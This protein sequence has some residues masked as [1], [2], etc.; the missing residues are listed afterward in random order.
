MLLENILWGCSTGKRREET[1]TVEEV[2]SW[3]RRSSLL[4]PKWF[5][6]KEAL[7]ITLLNNCLADG[8]TER[9]KFFKIS[10]VT[11]LSKSKQM[12]VLWTL[13]IRE[14]SNHTLFCVLTH[15][16]YRWRQSYKS[17]D[18]EYYSALK[19]RKSCYLRQQGW[20]LRALCW[21]Q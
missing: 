4:R 12:T 15:Y 13:V 11:T 20:T 5:S 3:G 16:G 9:D 10:V 17:D 19:R 18:M 6:P 1:V 14:I 2:V 7:R 8:Q 21:V